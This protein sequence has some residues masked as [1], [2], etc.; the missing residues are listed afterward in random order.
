MKLLPEFPGVDGSQQEL[1]GEGRGR[2]GLEISRNG[3]RTIIKPNADTQRADA[4]AGGGGC[5]PD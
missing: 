2:S 5:E 4:R 3:V 1:T